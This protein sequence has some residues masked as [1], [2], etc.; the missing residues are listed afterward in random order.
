MDLIHAEASTFSQLFCNEKYAVPEFQRTFAWKKAHV[1]DF[2]EDLNEAINNDVYHFLGSIVLQKD[3]E[4][5][6]STIFDGQQRLTVAVALISIIKF[7]LIELSKQITDKALSE[8]VDELIR[9]TKKYLF[10]RN[11]ETFLILSKY[12]QKFFARCLSEPQN[13]SEDSKETGFRTN[14][15][16]YN[17]VFQ[18]LRKKVREALRVQKSNEEKLE[19]LKRLFE[20]ITEKIYFV[21]TFADK[22]FSSATLFETG[23]SLTEDDLFKSFVLITAA[24]QSKNALK[25]VSDIWE[26][27]VAAKDENKVSLKEFLS[28]KW[29]ADN[30]KLLEGSLHKVLKKELE[31]VDNLQMSNY[32]RG[33][34]KIL[35]LY[36]DIVKPKKKDRWENDRRIYR[37]LEAISLLQYKECYPALL[38]LF[39]LP[40]A[41][42]F[43]DQREL[44]R[45][46]K[47]LLG[48]IEN[49]AFR[50]F[51]CQKDRGDDLAKLYAQY[52]KLLQ[53]DFLNHSSSFITHLKKFFP[54]DNEFEKEF[55]AYSSLQKPM[56]FYILHK[57]E[58][59]KVGRAES[60]TEDAMAVNIEHIM[61]RSPGRG[62]KHV[63]TYHGRLLN[64]IG[65]L[66]L[67]SRGLNIGN[68]SFNIKKE[69]YYKQSNVKLTK[70]LMP[71]E[72]WRKAEIEDRQKKLAK[73]AVSVWSKEI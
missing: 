25:K 69:K 29:T 14:E 21:V 54:S 43:N 47:R 15:F 11:E 19:S 4:A 57:L 62:W 7:E 72:K 36:V 65:N 34:K 48:V 44:A 13:L 45:L 58:K 52:A 24:N 12:N 41:G 31:S 38:S 46:K 56:V 67:L 35:D 63:H 37:S 10:D 60:I 23:A 64:R 61:P 20:C 26:E 59:Y 8:I 3:R 2:W 71:Y 53:E 28:D 70:E 49:L 73:L 18:N 16:L 6:H 66:T 40:S 39:S 42:Y 27:I 5:N 51:I 30:G 1:N 55:S 32:V 33:L 50:L 9:K 22:Q 68:D 17:A